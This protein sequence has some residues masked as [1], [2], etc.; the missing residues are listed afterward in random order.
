MAEESREELLRREYHGQTARIHW[1]ELQTYFAHGSV[2]AVN[3]SSEGREPTV[4]SCRSVR[5]AG[6]ATY[7]R[8]F[9]TW[10]NSARTARSSARRPTTPARKT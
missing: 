5:S 1:H 8:V 4:R 3:S 6:R 7:S 2:V 10:S 9:C